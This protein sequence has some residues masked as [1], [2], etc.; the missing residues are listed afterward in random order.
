MAAERTPGGFGSKLREARERRGITLRQI[1]NATKIS[2]SA[3][4]ALERNDI[5]RLPGGIFSRAFVR[6][7]AIEV[8]LDPEDTIQEFIAQFPHDTITA[9]HPSSKPI[10]D[11]EALES[12][13]RVAS[14]VLRLL[15]VSLPIAGVVIYF[16]TAG[17]PTP[18]PRLQTPTEATA[19]R[20]S[21][22]AA[23][24]SARVEETRPVAAPPSEV[25]PPG[26]PV[27]EAPPLPPADRLVVGLSATG[28]CWVS[29]IVDGQR[30]IG[31]E[32]Q[33]DERQVLDVKRDVILSVGDA[34]AISVTLN[35]AP[36]KPGGKAGQRG[37]VQMNQNNFKNFLAVP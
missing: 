8:G 2:I 14:T 12:D 26:P 18:E 15:A 34:G 19:G 24:S 20:S 35:G 7:Y 11:N 21:P 37:T 5:L 17:T 25:P 6:S 13:R 1:A 29:A 30:V 32:M 10:E 16:G 4:E 23:R 33:A 22:P 3:L 36:A 28:R 9:G 31:R 27:G